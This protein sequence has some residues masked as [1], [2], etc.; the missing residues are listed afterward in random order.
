VLEGLELKSAEPEEAPPPSSSS[1]G[2]GASN[3]KRAA[4]APA[5]VGGGDGDEEADEGGDDHDD[6][7]GEA[8]KQKKE[9][10]KSAF[11]MMHRNRSIKPPQAGIK[12]YPS[13]PATALKGVTVVVSGVLDSMSREM[14]T[15]F[16]TKHGGAMSKAVTKKT[17]HLV[18]DHG[19]VLRVCKP[20][21]THMTPT[22]PH[23]AL[24]M[25]FLSV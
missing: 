22:H 17:T 3:L 14:M 4:S 21:G 1:K 18:N 16:V 5:K 23:D 8:K 12:E 25:C 9:E 7:E 2:K 11:F 15:D 6:G 19:E 13:G 24:R 10:A 20:K